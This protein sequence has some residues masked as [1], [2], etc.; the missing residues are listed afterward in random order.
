MKF[1]IFRK[2]KV[3]YEYPPNYEQIKTFFQPVKGTYFAYYP[4]VYNPDNAVMD[5]PIEEHEAVHIRQQKEIGVEKWWSR[6]CIDKNFRTSQ[7]IEAYQAQY[8]SGKKLIKDKN[9]LARWTS[10]LAKEL[11]GDLYGNILSYNQA[12][13]AIQH[14]KPIRFTIKS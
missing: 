10:V 6:Y 9:H 13:A 14:D 5:E 12:L 2:I 4:Y 7:E 8:R 11:S 3:K 1:N